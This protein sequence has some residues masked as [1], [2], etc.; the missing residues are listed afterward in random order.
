MEKE[1]QPTPKKLEKARKAGKVGKSAILTRTSSLIAA[2]TIIFNMLPAYWVEVRLLLEYCFNSPANSPG[3]CIDGGSKLAMLFVS[4]V[5]LTTAIVTLL[6]EYLQVGVRI[7]SGILVPKLEHLNPLSGVRRICTGFKDIGTRLLFVLIVIILASLL[8]NREVIRLVN[9]TMTGE[10][11][12]MQGVAILMLSLGVT[13]FA[14]GSVD[15]YSKR[16]RF[17]KEQSMSTREI[18]DEYRETEGDPQFKSMR[19]SMHEE[20]AL[21]E[22]VARVKAANVIVVERA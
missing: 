17:M 9:D 15:L 10:L 11:P 21:E 20:L 5:L 12:E 18:R 6:V 3:A 8:L 16:R 4:Q 13:L 14:Y 19:K 22:L 1:H 2:S 7:D